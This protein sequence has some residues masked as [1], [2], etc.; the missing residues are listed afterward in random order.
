MAYFDSYSAIVS[1][2]VETAE[3]DSQE[4]LDFIPKSLE[5]AQLRIQD[6]LDID[7][8]N[9]PV[10][11]TCVTSNRLVLKPQDL[12]FI[13]N[14]FVVTSTG[15]ETPLK[16]VSTDYLRDYA[17]DK[18]VTG[19]PKYYSTDYSEEYLML[20]PT[21]ASA[22]TL[23]L[24]ARSDATLISPTNPQNIFTRRCGNVL[25]F[26]TMKEQASFMKNPQ[27]KQ[28]FEEKYLNA[29]QGLNNRGRRDRRQD[30][31][32]ATTGESGKN[33]LMGTK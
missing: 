31:G 30:G 24:D 17:P 4:F 9:A 2:I 23:M 1:S 14:M 29:V 26:A 10:E 5:L 13:N 6:E 16:K 28:E 21:P 27:M 12:R 20:A 3:D 11:L 18:S 8:L 33:T 19:E 22:Y 15:K 25:F 7:Q 32:S